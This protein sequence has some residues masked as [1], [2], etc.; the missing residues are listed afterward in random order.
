MTKSKGYYI[1]II[2]FDVIIFIIK[3]LAK[4]ESLIQILFQILFLQWIRVL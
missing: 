4:M 3:R 2:D 1:L